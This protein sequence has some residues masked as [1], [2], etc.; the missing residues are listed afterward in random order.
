MHYVWNEKE[1]VKRLDSYIVIIIR[2]YHSFNFLKDSYKMNLLD[3]FSLNSSKLYFQ[4]Q[5]GADGTSNISF[6]SE[7]TNY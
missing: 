3:F 2:K 6:Y 5:E 1:T 7:N 4:S